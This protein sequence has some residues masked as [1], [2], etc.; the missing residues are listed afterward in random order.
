[1]CDRKREREKERERER[2][3]EKL[4]LHLFYIDFI[5]INCRVKN[6]DDRFIKINNLYVRAYVSK[7][8]YVKKIY[9][10]AIVMENLSGQKN[11]N[12]Q[13]CYL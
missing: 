6:L 13:Y 12:V 1:V 3:R 8:R 9:K 7:E 11:L 4:I 10:D 2:E 5:S